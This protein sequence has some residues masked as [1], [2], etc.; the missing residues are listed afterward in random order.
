[1]RK[2]EMRPR[3][4]YDLRSLVAYIS[5][6]LKQ[7]DAA[8][9]IKEDLVSAIKALANTPT[10]GRVLSDKQLKTNYRSWLVGNYRII[11]TCDD[12]TLTVWRILHVRQDIDD[13]DLIDF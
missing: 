9:A 7:P 6:V 13:Y 5:Y 2:I 11:Y 8:R 10:I 4:K 1:M 3:A 12:N